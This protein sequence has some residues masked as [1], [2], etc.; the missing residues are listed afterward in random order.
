MDYTNKGIVE[1]KF[2]GSQR[3]IKNY[4]KMSKNKLIEMLKANDNDSTVLNDPEF[5]E[6][7]RTYSATWRQNNPERIL[8]YRDK[9]REVIRINYHDKKQAAKE[10]LDM[11]RRDY[12]NMTIYE[13]QHIGRVRKI[14]YFNIMHKVK[15][16]EMLKINDDDPSIKSDPEFDKI[17]KES[18]L[19]SCRKHREKKKANNHGF[20]LTVKKIQQ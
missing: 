10:N 11:S 12:E 9:F 5:D 20:L 3:K 8:N 7:C 13:L 1:L 17:C 16:I 2:I 15:L 6:N 18:N 4:M 14:K 19:I